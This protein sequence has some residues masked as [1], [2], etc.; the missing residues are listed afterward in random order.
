MGLSSVQ[1]L[2]FHEIFQV[3]IIC[4]DLKLELCAFQYMSLLWDTLDRNN[5][6]FLFLLFSDFIGILFLFLFSFSFG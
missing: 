4:P 5:F 3:F 1:F 6:Y 2:C